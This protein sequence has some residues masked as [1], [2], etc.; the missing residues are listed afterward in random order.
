MRSLSVA[1]LVY[2]VITHALC[3]FKIMP[4]RGN[5]K[6]GNSEQ[7]NSDGSDFVEG[8]NAC[9]YTVPHSTVSA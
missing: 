5:K 1:E 4:S 6:Y 8:Q 9:I 3:Y 2:N 7:Q